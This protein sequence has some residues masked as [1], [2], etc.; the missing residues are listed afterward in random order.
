M[1]NTVKIVLVI[2]GT[3]I[4]A[5]FA[6]GKEIYIFFAKYGTYGIIGIGISAIITSIVTYKTLKI[7]KQKQKS[8]YKELLQEINPKGKRTNKIINY[9]VN[10]F[11]LTSFFIM[12]AGFSAY[13]KQ[14]FQIN[15]YITSAVFVTICYIILK[16][17]I[18]GVIKINELLV[19]MLIAF[20]IYLGMKNIGNIVQ[21]ETIKTLEIGPK[22]IIKSIIS[23][24]LY[25]S[26]NSIIL[27]PVLANLKTYLTEEKTI[28]K[29]A[30]LTGITISIL[31][32]LIYGLLL[33][34]I[35]YAIELEMPLIQIVKEYG[36][37]SKIIYEFVIIASIFTSAISTVNSFLVNTTNQNKNKKTY[38]III[39]IIGVIISNI[40]FSKLVQ[41]LYPLF[42]V[43]GL[44]QI[45]KILNS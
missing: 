30:I 44:I 14:T 21:V 23:S 18:K 36:N 32:L 5:G 7:V 38:L 45:K 24:I 33:K 1:K 27:I 26:Y 2:I 12:I 31:A 10:A 22:E 37:I 9:I 20:I 34:G 8:N 39:C 28:K 29:V 35:H 41:I 17:N 13:L 3:L 16:Q 6:S 11:L 15:T 25:A 4:G 43:L 40:G 42:G 19:P